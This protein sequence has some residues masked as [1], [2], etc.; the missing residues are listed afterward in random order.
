[1]KLKRPGRIGLWIVSGIL[2][3]FGAGT[4]VSGCLS[5][6]AYDGPTTPHFD[7][8]RFRNRVEVPE[9]SL[10]DLL[11]WWWERDAPEW[12]D[13]PS[14][15]KHAAPPERVERGRLRATFINHATVLLQLDGVNILTD[16]VFSERVGP[17]SW[18]GPQRH[19]A[20]GLKPEALP[21]IDA[22]LV[23]HN[24]YDHMDL[25]SLRRI[26][27]D[28]EARILVGLGN[29]ALLEKNE[30]P[31]G[32]ELDWWQ[33]TRVGAVTVTFVP[34]RHWSGRGLGDRFQTLWGGFVVQGAGGPV[35]FAGDTGW[36]PHFDEA[37]RRFGPMRLA[38]LPIGAYEPRWFMKAAH[39]S[40]DEAVGAHLELHAR[41]SLAI[42]FGT[43][44]LSDE[45][46][47]QPPR[48]LRRAMQERR[49]EAAGTAFWVL[50]HG[51]GRDV[52]PL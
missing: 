41:T 5:A 26:A 27:R 7:G 21:P 18:A 25:P 3:L 17:V 8:E 40:P 1:M 12:Q 19:R 33:S 14:T 29:G 50:D 46:Q 32:E 13:Q 42:H 51:E 4:L 15:T 23:S 24:H 6:P 44:R 45:G 2:L 43:F 49:A 38:L 47:D 28:H 11:A 48:D 35:Y 39:I 20:P 31:G 52:P 30:I 10:W 22:V 34:A 9:K 16:P 37:R 36:G